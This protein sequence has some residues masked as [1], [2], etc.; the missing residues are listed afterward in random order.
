MV[1]SSMEPDA[2]Q[3]ENKPFEARYEF[4]DTAQKGTPMKRTPTHF[5]VTR[6]YGLVLILLAVPLL[7]AADLFPTWQEY[8]A[9]ANSIAGTWVSSQQNSPED[10]PLVWTE[11]VTPLNSTGTRFAY[12]ALS[13]NPQANWSFIGLTGVRMHGQAL[14]ELVQTGENEYT[15][16]VLCHAAGPIPDEDAHAEVKWLWY[17]VGTAWLSDDGTLVKDGTW[18]LYNSVDVFDGA[19]PDK[20][21]DEDGLPDADVQPLMCGPW[22]M[23]SKRI[24]LQPQIIVTYDANGVC[25]SPADFCY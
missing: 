25:Q 8:N 6:K 7:W 17:W 2:D 21:M 23:E 10:N 20:D 3:T 16:T 14:G 4:S 19:F 5:A 9:S 1:V 15:F 11:I 12:Q 24:Q 18:Q 13:P 22:P